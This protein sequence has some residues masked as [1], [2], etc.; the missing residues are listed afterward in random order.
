MSKAGRY[1]VVN[2]WQS[3]CNERAQ[4]EVEWL[5]LLKSRGNWLAGPRMQ[6]LYLVV[7]SSTFQ[8]EDHRIRI[9][10]QCLGLSGRCLHTPLVMTPCGAKCENC[11]EFGGTIR[12][13][14][15][16]QPIIN[17]KSKAQWTWGVFGGAHL[18][19]S[20][21][22]LTCTAHLY[23]SPVL[24]TCTA[25]LYCSPVLLTCP[26]PWDFW[27]H[28]MSFLHSERHRTSWWTWRETSHSDTRLLY[29][30]ICTVHTFY[31]QWKCHDLIM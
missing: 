21:V 7:F 11:K 3:K 17:S 24:L 20:P 16:H 13:L 6:T 19:C 12:V 5:M 14:R 22:L 2:N 23:C 4:Q 31:A 9:A 28:I 15:M 30:M 1:F 8:G 18:Y 25:H 27:A 26:A 29:V 10:F